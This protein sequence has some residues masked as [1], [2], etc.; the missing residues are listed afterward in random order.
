MKWEPA[1]RRDMLETIRTGI[2]TRALANDIASYKVRDL[3]YLTFKNDM[4]E[5][6]RN[7]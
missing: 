5:F 3:I 1:E 6:G 7:I 2:R 4:I